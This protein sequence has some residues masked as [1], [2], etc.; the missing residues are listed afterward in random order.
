MKYS[1]A[2]FVEDYRLAD[3][4]HIIET[5][6]DTLEEAEYYYNQYNG[7]EFFDRRELDADI[8]EIRYV[9]IINLID[10]GNIVGLVKGKF[11]GL[12]LEHYYPDFWELFHLLES[13]K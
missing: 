2:I 13:S 8:S 5:K 6:F 10:N 11:K 4:Y 12:D 9:V 7:I 1:L 3:K